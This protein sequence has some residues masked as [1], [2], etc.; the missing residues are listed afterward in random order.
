MA[1]SKSGI[2]ICC[3]PFVVSSSPTRRDMSFEIDK[4]NLRRVILNSAAQL[5]TDLKFSNQLFLKRRRFDKVIF[6]G[7]G[8][9]A[10]AGDLLAGLKLK[11]AAEFSISVPAWTHRSYGLP[12]DCN[13]NT[14]LICISYSGNTEETISVLDEAKNKG[15]EIA[16]IA[17]GGKLEDLFERNKTPWV[18]IPSGLPPRC[19]LGYQ[20][21]ALV[22]ILVGYGIIFQSSQE[23]LR[24]L[25][26]QIDPASI[27]NEAKIFCQKLNHKI[28]IIYS[29]EENKILARITKIK[30]NENSKIPAFWNSLPEMNH[31]E[32][33]GWTKN[34]G[35]F[36]F[37]FLK[38]E[39]DLPR[40]QKRMEFTARLI[41]KTGLPVDFVEMKGHDALE[42]MF[43]ML[44]F[45]D[46]VSYHLALF[47]GIDPFPVEI[48]EE[49]KRQLE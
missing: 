33:V 47:Y 25:G 16:G 45:G 2:L 30:F 19:A 15:I 29:S 38:D 20:F 7:M 39:T 28:P 42:R 10:L 32:M 48:V 13:E 22:K 1:Y 12:Q 4:S 14:L 24:L 35:P 3:R 49:F 21:S 40:I 36:S 6:C 31:N 43:W 27:E 18:K 26:G 5:R 46:W 17:S 8:G 44:A 41:R 34:L 9:S 37:I 11:K 23:K